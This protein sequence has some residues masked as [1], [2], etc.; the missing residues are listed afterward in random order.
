MQDHRHRLSKD[1]KGIM[2]LPIRLM[3]T[4]MVIAIALPIIMTA[5]D[6]SEQD[7]AGAEM[8]KEAEKF[9]NAAVLAHYSGNGC[10]RTVQLELPAGCELS[11]GGQGGDAYSIRMSYNGEVISTVYFES[12]PL[13]IIQPMTFTGNM[14]LKLTSDETVMTPQIK[15]AVL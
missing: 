5:M 11:V 13:M 3:V 2:S 12:P 4:M 8:E 14:T 10:S 7:M 15:V 1:R 6:G 9:R